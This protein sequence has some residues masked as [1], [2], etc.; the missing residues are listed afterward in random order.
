MI[1]F[2]TQIYISPYYRG[3][4]FYHPPTTI[5]SWRV[6]HGVDRFRILKIVIMDQ[7]CF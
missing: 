7:N 2:K 3:H 1:I 5:S 6:H 4:Y